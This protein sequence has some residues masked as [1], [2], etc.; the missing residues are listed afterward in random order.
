MPVL[1]WLVINRDCQTFTLFRSF[2]FVLRVEPWVW[3][4]THNSP[5]KRAANISN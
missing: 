5:T 4:V 2:V 1:L 3:R